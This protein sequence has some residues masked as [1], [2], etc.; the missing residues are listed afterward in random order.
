MI[1]Y[2]RGEDNYGF[3]FPRFS[4]LFVKPWPQ[5]LSP[6]TFS[7]KPKKPKNPKKGPWADTK[8][9]WATI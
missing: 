6:K 2:R 8:I 5:T 4:R 3:Y 1:Q 9:S 7:P